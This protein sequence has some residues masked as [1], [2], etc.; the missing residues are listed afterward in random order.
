MARI[1]RL[2]SDLA[3]QIAAGEVVERPASVVKELVENA[4]DAGARRIAITVDLGGKRLIRVEDD[5][6]GMEP[7]DARLAIER[8][9][10]SK[11]R[12]ADDLGAIRTLGFRGEAL[13]S[14]A[15]V[16]RFT[17]RTRAKGSEGGTEVTVN[18]GA[19]AS[20]R[21]VGAPEGTS[22]E[23]ADLF[24]NLPARRKFLK[25]DTAETTQISRLATQLAL[26]YP[27]VGFTLTSSGPSTG[28]GHGRL[29]LQCPPASCARD[30]FFQLFG[31]RPDLV[32][33]RKDAA[34]LHIEG[35][36]AA[37]GDQGPTRGA[38][39]VFVNRRIVKDRTIAHA[40]IDAYSVATIKE[41]S[42]EVHLFLAIAPDRVDVNVHP[43]KAEVRFLEQSLVHEVLRRALGDALGH[44]RAPEIQF[45]LESGQSVLADQPRPMSI[46]GVM[47]G[48][49]VG[50]R[51]SREAGQVES[52]IPDPRSLI[53]GPGSSIAGRSSLAGDPGSAS[54]DQGTGDRS[55]AAT[56]IR[57]MIPLGQFRDTFI[58]A[59]DDEGVAIIDQH[60]AHER[61]LFEQITERLTSG[62]LESQRLLTPILLE[63]S[64]AQRAALEQHRAT[65]ER[66][67]MELEAF[68]GDSVRLSAVPALLEPAECEA[69]IRALADDLDGLRGAAG[70]EDALRR[71][72]ATT[73]CHAAVK[74][75]YPLTLDKMRYIL[76]ELRRTA[77]SSVCPHGRPV[78]LR[79]TRREIE[80]NFQRI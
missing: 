12:R 7:E 77:Y 61:V 51:W 45:R 22:I 44:G 24:Y 14:I 65:L 38:Q 34:G 67:G 66:F 9:A 36:I 27:E 63:L 16:S 17:L 80:K 75:N 48:A 50:N 60:V 39:N 53:G 20:V 70:A 13:P 47:A 73:A 29:L 1:H 19:V 62:R 5:G 42:P 52:L 11:I 37:L 59:I 55:A 57:P 69:T 64:P 2:P 26:A 71:I 41:R 15:S 58:I 56:D 21:E 76:E 30:R 43:T 4:L 31:D 3:D 33:V 49:L 25:S 78:V 6:E 72:A 35:Y 18:A 23:V 8:H 54:V 40:I 74:A 32:E 28:S 68:G 79:L 46:P 10:T